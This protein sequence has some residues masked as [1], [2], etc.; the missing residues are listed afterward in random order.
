VAGRDR[1]CQAG[2]D[3]GPLP[4]SDYRRLV[5]PQVDPGIAFMGGFGQHRRVRQHLE[6]QFVNGRSFAWHA[7][8]TT[9]GRGGILRRTPE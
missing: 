4:R 3:R 2:A 6:T 9:G 8:Q 5:G 1:D 7:G